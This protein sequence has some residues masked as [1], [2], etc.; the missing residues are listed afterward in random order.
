MQ[1]F[2]TLA[3]WHE[4]GTELSIDQYMALVG[5]IA[6]LKAQIAELQEDGARENLRIELIEEQHIAAIDLMREIK[7]AL[8]YTTAKAIK[9][10]ICDAIDDSLFEF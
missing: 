8:R 3:R 1:D 7:G 9:Q 6:Q 10:A 5:G 4:N 2:N